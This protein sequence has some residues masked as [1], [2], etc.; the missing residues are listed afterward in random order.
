MSSP[1]TSH[2]DRLSRRHLLRGATGSVL[3]ALLAACGAA[4][5]GTTSTAPSSTVTAAAPAATAISTQAASQATPGTSAPRATGSAA[6]NLRVASPFLPKSLDPAIGT[7][8]SDIMSLGLGET[9]TRITPQGDVQPWLAESVEPMDATHWRI[10]LRQGVTFH[11]GKPLDAAAAQA[12]L[13]RTLTKNASAAGLLVLN[14]ID[15]QD[16]QT[17]VLETKGPNGGIPA[18]LSSYLLMI[19]DAS[20]A[21]QMGDDAFGQRPVMTGPFQAGDFRTGESVT[22]RRYDGYWQGAPAL[23]QVEFRNVA[24]G[25]ARLAAVLAG[26]VDLARQIPPQGVAQVQ[27][28]KLPLTSVGSA[29]VYHIYFNSARPPLDDTAVRRALT[30]AVD[31]QTLRDRVLG[32]GEIARG[33]YPSYLPFA[34]TAPLPF[35]LNQARQLLDAAGWRMGSDGVRA[36]GGQRLAFE[37]LTYPQR[38]EL[39]LLATAIQAQLKDVGVAISIRS[40]EDI[41]T[42]VNAGDYTAA[43]YAFQTAPTGDPSFV[44]NVLYRSNGG[45][46][47]QLGYHSARLDAAADALV[48]ETDPV[49][50]VALARQAQQILIE[51]APAAYLLQPLYHTAYVSKLR[52]FEPHP[53]EQYL[54]TSRWSLA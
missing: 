9:F 33:I 12:S 14:R 1:I 35:D 52:G 28:A 8:G 32:G 27:A 38:P 51:D 39:G 15:V 41:S 4:S 54:L 6:G 23:G 48:P 44:L 18:I 53:V 21:T 16:A 19:H 40:T 50:R 45:L 36:K 46:N 3:T 5:P 47:K 29:Y 43:M 7:Q 26:D 30:L 22:V 34:G 20:A 10:R 49:K 2:V 13:N 37:V 31:R 24:D 42:P 11:N 17:L 25:N